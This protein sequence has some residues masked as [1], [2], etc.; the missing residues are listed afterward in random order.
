MI[1]LGKILKHEFGSSQPLI[2]SNYSCKADSDCLG[3]VSQTE[4]VACFFH[5]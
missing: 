1:D 2:S 4:F 5:L 3:R